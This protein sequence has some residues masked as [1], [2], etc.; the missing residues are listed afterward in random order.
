MASNSG[1]NQRETATAVLSEEARQ[2]SA[3]NVRVMSAPERENENVNYTS[4][5]EREHIVLARNSGAQAPFQSAPSVPE[6]GRVVLTRNSGAQA[7]YEAGLLPSR[8]HACLE[9]SIIQSDPS[10]PECLLMEQAAGQMPGSCYG[11]PAQMWPFGSMVQRVTPGPSQAPLTTQTPGIRLAA[12]YGFGSQTIWDSWTSVPRYFA[13]AH[14][15]GEL[16]PSM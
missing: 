10:L 8:Q 9:N 14:C 4:A 12:P 1:L 5:P 13:D 6:K 3:P 15:S 16:L 7:R 11:V 2:A